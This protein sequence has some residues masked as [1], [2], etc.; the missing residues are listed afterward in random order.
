MKQCPK[1]NYTCADEDVICKNCGYLFSTENKIPEQ[2][3]GFED[4]SNVT[5]PKTN[6]M[7]IASLV[8]G[9]IGVVTSCCYIGI[10][11]GILSLIFGIIS[12]KRIKDSNGREKG[13]GLAIAGIILSI[14]AIVFAIYAIINLIINGPE[15]FRKMDEALKHQSK[16]GY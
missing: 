5:P 3:Y 9:I 1:C 7:S 8:L 6:G 16:Y 14:V 4:A 11:P 12:K 13:D 15:I 2:Q 10:I